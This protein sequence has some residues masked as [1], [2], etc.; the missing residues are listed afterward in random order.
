VTVQGYE[1]RRDNNTSTA[2][3]SA[4]YNLVSTYLSANGE[5]VRFT[6]WNEVAGKPTNTGGA[7]SAFGNGE[8]TNEVY[9]YLD[10]NTDLTLTV[11][12]PNYI[13]DCWTIFNNFTLTRY[14][15]KVTIDEDEDYE[16]VAVDNANVTFNRTLV[17]GWNGMVLPF[18]M[19]ADEVKT[20]FNASAVKDFKGVT[21]NAD[22]SATLEFEDATDVQAGKPFMMKADEAGTSY[23]INGVLLPATGLQP[24]SQE[25]GDVKYTF[26]GSYAASTDLSNVVFALI[27]GDKYF[28]HNTG[29]P[30]SAKAFRAW[31]VN[32]STDEAGSRISFNFG[33]DVITGIN[34][35]QTNGQDAEAVYNLQGQR[36]VNAKKGLFIQNGKKVVIK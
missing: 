17:K 4:G 29:K 16:P 8:A 24:V 10:G 20:A 23:T 3:Y 34:E 19:T 15:V 21:V 9:V 5:Q 1:R 22:G 13:W 14:D 32:E 35:V 25:S 11:R 28:Y 12:K 26:T 33:D 36:V 7:V 27:Q 6:D 30:S 18:N 31:F 2:L